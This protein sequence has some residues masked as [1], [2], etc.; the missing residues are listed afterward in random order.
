M[1][2][3][4]LLK[5]TDFKKRKFPILLKTFTVN[6]TNKTTIMFFGFICQNVSSRVL[7]I[8][9][10]GGSRQELSDEHTVS[11]VRQFW[12]FDLN[13]GVAEL[14][15]DRGS[16]NS[17]ESRHLWS[18]CFWHD[19]SP[20]FCMPACTAKRV[21]FGTLICILSTLVKDTKWSWLSWVTLP[22]MKFWH[23]SFRI[24]NICFYA[25][26][27]EMPR[28]LSCRQSCLRSKGVREKYGY[29]RLLT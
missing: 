21:L 4:K 7:R 25:S 23:W 11:F 2:I 27:I 3:W 22:K 8:S 20:Y 24:N 19:R 12:I 13:I 18:T 17:K 16:Q 14:L 15:G 28:R 10:I 26:Q 1:L 9:Q 6:A 29:M 5:L